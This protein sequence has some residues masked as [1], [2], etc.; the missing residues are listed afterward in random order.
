MRVNKASD[1]VC[2]VNLSE[3]SHHQKPVGYEL[4]GHA[5]AHRPADHPAREQVK[6]CCAVE[7]VVR[8]KLGERARPLPL[9]VTKDAATKWLFASEGWRNLADG[10]RSTLERAVRSPR[11]RDASGAEI[12]RKAKGNRR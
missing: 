9:A 10:A 12:R 4:G 5:R 7:E 3:Q 6:N 1:S 11:E 8:L 2:M